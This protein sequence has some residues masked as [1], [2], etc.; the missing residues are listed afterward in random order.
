MEVEVEAMVELGVVVGVRVKVGEGRKKKAQNRP[1]TPLELLETRFGGQI[2][3]NWHKGFWGSKGVNPF[4]SCV[5]VQGTSYLD[6][7]VD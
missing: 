6:L 5:H 4:K 1:L 7:C 3:W 2:P